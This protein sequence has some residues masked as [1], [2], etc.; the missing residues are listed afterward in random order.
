MDEKIIARNDKA[1]EI[2]RKYNVA[3][4]AA[5]NSKLRQ[6]RQL[7]TEH[8]IASKTEIARLMMLGDTS[9]SLI[10]RIEDFRQYLIN[11]QTEEVNGLKFLNEVELNPNPCTIHANVENLL[12]TLME[13]RRTHKLLSV[14]EGFVA[15]HLGF[16][17]DGFENY[18]ETIITILLERTITDASAD[19]TDF[20]K[21][22]L[23]FSKVLKAGVTVKNCEEFV[24]KVFEEVNLYNE[25]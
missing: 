15:A 10:Q 1:N 11:V 2:Y 12:W 17:S 7:T 13:S 4:A 16:N 23:D 19:D 8:T 14:F 25:E 21:L 22:Q 5:Y 3:H 18:V 6:Q 9:V 24:Q 20:V